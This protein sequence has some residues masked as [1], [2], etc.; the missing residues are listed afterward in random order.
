KCKEGEEYKLCSSK[1]EPTCLNQNPICNLICLPPKC[2]CKQG[3]VRNNNVCILKEKCLK[4]V[5]N[6]NCGIFYICKII[7]GKAKCVPPY[8]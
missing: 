3:Y 8:N 4:P 7:N 1:C 2:Q 6:I 5:C